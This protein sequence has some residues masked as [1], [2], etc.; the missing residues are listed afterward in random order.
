MVWQLNSNIS[1]VDLYPNLL[2]NI[3]SISDDLDMGWVGCNM[4][5]KYK[6]EFKVL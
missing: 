2:S 1:L 4:K 6:F 3:L 5:G